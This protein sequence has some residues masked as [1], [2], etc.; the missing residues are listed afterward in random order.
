M[1][2][3]SD[4]LSGRCA[5][6]RRGQG[7][8]LRLSATGVYRSAPKQH[9]LFSTSYHA[10]TPPRPCTC[11]FGTASAASP[12]SPPPTAA[13]APPTTPPSGPPARTACTSPPCP[14]P[15]H[16]GVPSVGGA[17]A[18]GAHCQAAGAAP[19]AR[20][21]Y[22]LA[23]PWARV[24]CSR[25]PDP[26]DST[27]HICLSL[28]SATVDRRTVS[29]PAHSP[30]AS[31]AYWCVTE[32]PDWHTTASPR[33]TAQYLRHTALAAEQ[34][35]KASQSYCTRISGRQAGMGWARSMAKHSQPHSHRMSNSASL[36][37]DPRNP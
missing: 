31:T 36:W 1:R 17:A 34:A 25:S 23:S 8:S 35:R 6:L 24:S 26:A 32:I 29:P 15:S 3:S 11:T 14:P 27:V 7:N 13:P 2:G 10:T 18:R 5:T 16:S 12:P 28:C 9:P 21:S 33:R 37:A 20:M 22:T 4:L 30:E 19:H